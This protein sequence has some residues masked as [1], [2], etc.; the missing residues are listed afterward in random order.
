MTNTTWNK[1]DFNFHG[2]YLTY[3]NDFVARF[4]YRGGLVTMGMFKKALVK[5]NL[6]P[7]QYMDLMADSKNT[8]MGILEADGSLKIEYD[9][10]GEGITLR[11]TEARVY[12][13]GKLVKTQ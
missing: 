3:N 2:G 9:W 5:S 13:A 6:T 7:K 8:P 11:I 1:D 10:E 12:V 4:K